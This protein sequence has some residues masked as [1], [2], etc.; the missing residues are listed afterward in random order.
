MREMLYEWV[1]NIVFYQMITSIII[2][3]IPSNAYV[4]YIR[5]F[6][7]MLFVLIAIQPLLKVVRLAE[8]V[9]V[10]YVHEVL[11]QELE[12]QDFELYLEE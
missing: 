11:E 8:K 4:K 5:F 7:G 12:E 9:D 1:R 10:S 3:L 2:N 6:M